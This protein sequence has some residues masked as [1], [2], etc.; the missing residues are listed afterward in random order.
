MA[1]S[2]FISVYD[3]C[4]R[5]RIIV[6]SL[7]A[8]LTAAA[9]LG[10]TQI[11][12]DSSLDVMLPADESVRRSVRFLRSA[13]FSD[14]VVAS[15]S[16]DRDVVSERSFNNAIDQFAASA[17]NS[18]I[19]EVI[20]S[21]SSH[22]LMNDLGF[23][24]ENAP[25]IFGEDDMARIEVS[26][27]P[28]PV[29]KALRRRYMELLK[30]QG[31][32]MAS[33]IRTDPLGFNDII[34]EKLRRLSSSFGYDVRNE[35]GR[36]VSRDGMHRMLILTTSVPITDGRGSREL[37][38]HLESLVAD[39]PTG[40]NVN[41]V[42]GHNHTVSNERVIRADINR[43][44]VVAG[45]AFLI[46]FFAAFRDIRA[47]WIFVIPFASVVVAMNMTVLTGCGMSAFIVGMGAIIAG[48][49][50]DYGIH[51]YVAVRRGGNSAGTVR[52]VA[53]P[54]LLGALTTVSVF[55]VLLFSSIEGYRQLA[56]F[57][58][59]SIS[60]SVVYALFIL[61]QLLGG[62]KSG[63]NGSR[64][65]QVTTMSMSTRA[66]IILSYI[67]VMIVMIIGVAGITVDWDLVQLDGASRE[68]KEG[69][70][71]FRR[72]WGGGD[73]DRAM[74]V[75]VSDTHQAASEENDRIYE[76]LA[77]RMGDDKFAS[78]A[79]L[80]PSL[81]TRIIN[82]GR[83][84][85]FWTKEKIETL[86]DV[87]ADEGKDYSFS[88]GAFSP[89]RDRLSAQHSVVDVEPD[90]QLLTWLRDRF[91]LEDDAGAALI[92]YFPDKDEF[93]TQVRG[94]L[95]KGSFIVSRRELAADLSRSVSGEIILMS[96]LAMLAVVVVTLVSLRGTGLAAVALVPAGTGVVCM[97]G[98][99]THLGYAMNI[100]N[101]MAGIVVVGLCI[102]YGIFM[103]HSA[104]SV[105]DS[106]TRVAVTLSAVSTLAG[107]GAVLLAD[108]PALFSIGLTLFVG[109]LCGYV[110]AIVVVPALCGDRRHERRDA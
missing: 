27:G 54:V 64:G 57:S 16:Y 72:T 90:N 25:E 1:S 107:A 84:E 71:A 101:L 105:V 100:S 40:I 12:F 73:L 3:C 4:S 45:V 43:T 14:K 99:M 78:L 49:A 67:A 89:F 44:L 110:S 32:F 76:L 60:I 65:R 18:H 9:V 26:L 92:S 19:T 11:E 83:W 24:F 97:L 61:P 23:F 82:A 2:W 94:V 10:I 85:S 102:D 30:P 55:A 20:S 68:I 56:V 59:F 5:H 86:L 62:M 21:M 33:L 77:P 41:I 51:V 63:Q 88:K 98:M 108:H 95:R 15:F 42:C 70:K 8:A 74:C 58:A 66:W 48:I 75:V 81:R 109:V 22:E 6:V 80:W 93:L 79:L 52:L 50:V 87:L 29:R 103:V 34:S 17:P 91:V 31:S 13:K 38:A 96:S 7:L 37:L 28:G 46:L 106:G 39:L 47:V 69:E 104:C 35:S 53:K 36:L